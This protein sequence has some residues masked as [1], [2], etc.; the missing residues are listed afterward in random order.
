[1][2]LMTSERAWSMAM[3]LKQEANSQPRKRHHMVEKMRKAVSCAM[4]LNKLCEDSEK[5]DPRTK[6][7][8]QVSWTLW[9]F[10][11]QYTKLN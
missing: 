6:L 3:Y 5:V 7:E 11:V 2:L 10:F 8:A 4:E 9:L 1:M